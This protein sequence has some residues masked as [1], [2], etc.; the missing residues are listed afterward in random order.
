MNGPP[1]LRPNAP[2]TQSQNSG[3]GQPPFQPHAPGFQESYRPQKMD[4]DKPALIEEPSWFSNKVGWWMRKI[5][6]LK[7]IFLAA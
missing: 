5:F 3:P 6:E 7:Y 2:R 1:N 4:Y